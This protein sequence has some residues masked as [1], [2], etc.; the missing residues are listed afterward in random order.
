MNDPILAK[1]E[2]AYRVREESAVPLA[3][4]GQTILGGKVI[5]AAELMVLEGQVVALTLDDGTSI[6]KRVG[7]QISDAFPYLRQFE[8]VGGL[9]DS[10]V[11]AT[12][13]MEGA[14]N[15]PVMAYARP[16]IGVIYRH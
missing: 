12:E 4:P 6:L 7:S 10:V 13:A 5:A 16:I 1:V 15:V 8:A 9:G 2:V 11:I 14:P 3:L